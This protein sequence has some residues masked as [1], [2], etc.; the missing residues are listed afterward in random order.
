MGGAER[1]AIRP[2]G[3]LRGLL[4]RIAGRRLRQPERDR[5]ADARRALDG[6][7]AALQLD[8]RFRDRQAEPGTAV[9]PRVA[10]VDLLEPLERGFD[11][12]GAHADSRVGDGDFHGAAHRARP[13]NQGRGRSVWRPLGE[14]DRRTL[15]PTDSIWTDLAFRRFPSAMR[16]VFRQA[17]SSLGSRQPSGRI[18]LE[19]AERSCNEP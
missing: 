15:Q 12:A 18:G 8:E 4:Q 1:G 10:A 11:I 5:G 6:E 2:D 9:N 17:A 13:R 16:Q 7:R 19:C 3:R 14:R